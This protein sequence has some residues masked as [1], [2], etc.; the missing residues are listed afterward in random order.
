MFENLYN[1]FLF[2]LFHNFNYF[3]FLP[4]LCMKASLQFIYR[5]KE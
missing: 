2:V 3:I 4:M 1:L 5:F